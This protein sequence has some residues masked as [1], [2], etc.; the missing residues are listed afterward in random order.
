M[1]PSHTQKMRIFSTA[2]KGYKC[3]SV[4]IKGVGTPGL[5]EPRRETEVSVFPR[6]LTECQSCLQ[7]CDWD[8]DLHASMHVGMGAEVGVKCLSPT[9]LPHPTGN[10]H[11][12][13]SLLKLRV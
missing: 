4:L 1:P 12:N 8:G 6:F 10:L 11:L 7:G 2:Q 13:R 5:Q 9:L 3:W